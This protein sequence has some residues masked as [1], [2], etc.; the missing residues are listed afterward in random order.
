MRFSTGLAALCLVASL[1]TFT[2]R[3]VK[4]VEVDPQKDIP[5]KGTILAGEVNSKFCGEGGSVFVIEDENKNLEAMCFDTYRPNRYSGEVDVIVTPHLRDNGKQERIYTRY[6]DL[7]LFDYKSEAQYT[8][9]LLAGAIGLLGVTGISVVAG[10]ISQMIGTS[11]IEENRIKTFRKTLEQ[12]KGQ[13]ASF[14]LDILEGLVCRV[15]YDPK[16]NKHFTYDG[17]EVKVTPVG[18]NNPQLLNFHW[19]NSQR[20]E[21]SVLA[22]RIAE[23]A[24]KYGANAYMVGESTNAHGNNIYGYTLLK[25]EFFSVEEDPM[26]P[27]QLQPDGQL[28]PHNFVLPSQG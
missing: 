5:L 8:F 3:H 23:E 15:R 7:P 18:T 6:G 20:S 17:R 4:L 9:W 24:M 16:R 10:G 19:S 1:A 27:Y 2:Y 11:R 28:L 22:S 13:R 26:I 21:E 14:G 25:A 12:F